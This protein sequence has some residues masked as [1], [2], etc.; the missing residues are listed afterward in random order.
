MLTKRVKK[1]LRKTGIKELAIVGGVSANSVLQVRMNELTQVVGGRF[2]VPD[3]IYCTDNA[4]MI[5]IA[6]HHKLSAGETS[7]L[8]LTANPSLAIA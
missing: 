8:T 1:A 5:A 4:A 3:P 2:F 7:P 6:G